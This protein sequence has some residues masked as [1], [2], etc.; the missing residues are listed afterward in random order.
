MRRYSWQM[1]G[2]I[3]VSI[4]DSVFILLMLFSYLKNLTT[5]H[6]R[7]VVVGSFGAT[8][9]GDELLLA[10]CLKQLHKYAPGAQVTI[11][12]PDAAETRAWHADAP[13]A[14]RTAFPVPAGVRSLLHPERGSGVAA[15]RSAHVVVYAGGGLWT[16]GE[17]LRAL[18]QWSL[19]IVVARFFGKRVYLLGQSIGPLRSGIA[20]LLTRLVLRQAECVSVR[21]AASA[22]LLIDLGLVPQRIEQGRDSALYLGTARTARKFPRS[23]PRLLVSVREYAGVGEHTYREIARA[24]DILITRGY[25]VTFAPWEVRV[26]DDRRAW[27]RVVRWMQHAHAVTAEEIPRRAGQ[28]VPWVRTYDTVLAMRLH[29]NIAAHMAGVPSVAMSYAPKVADLLATLGGRARVVLPIARAE[30]MA[31]AVVDVAEPESSSKITGRG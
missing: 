17:S 4:A 24:L 22:E 30:E 7:I 2:R 14:F 20:R 25:H 23:A 6:P 29:A 18:V 5:Q 8:N 28:V 3:K 12:T 19:P 13:Y 15:L 11:L 9:V 27:Q 10:G 26:H 16:D 1:W 21:D 31:A